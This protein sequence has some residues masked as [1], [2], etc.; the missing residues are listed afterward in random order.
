MTLYAIKNGKNKKITVDGKS[1][2]DIGKKIKKENRN[3]VMKKEKTSSGFAF[4]PDRYI[5]FSNF[6][7]IN[8]GDFIFNTL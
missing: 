3:D 5:G 1:I 8:S 2:K 7:L 6:F 4:I